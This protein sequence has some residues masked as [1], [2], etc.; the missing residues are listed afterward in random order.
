[1]NLPHEG[2]GLCNMYA[3]EKGGQILVLVSGVKILQPISK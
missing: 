1:M 2:S 3:V